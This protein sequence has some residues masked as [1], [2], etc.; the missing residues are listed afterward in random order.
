MTPYVRGASLVW[1]AAAMIVASCGDELEAEV[2][3]ATGQRVLRVRVDLAETAEERRQGLRGRTQLGEREGLWLRFP[4]EGEVC[5]TN[6]GVGF[7]IDALFASREGTIVAVERAIA[8]DDGNP[9]CHD[10]TADVLEVR[11]GVAL[12]VGLGD[13]LEGP[14]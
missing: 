5:L 7:D 14:L 8:A 13:V 10:G 2:R 4:V 11:A 3:D 1:I 6:Q 9:R 12:G